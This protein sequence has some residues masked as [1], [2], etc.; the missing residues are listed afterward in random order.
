MEDG[1]V[2]IFCGNT[3]VPG[4]PNAKE[5]HNVK[6]TEKLLF[7]VVRFVDDNHSKGKLLKKLFRIKFISI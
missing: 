1:D 3:R 4:A 6:M 2:Y 5:S 7:E